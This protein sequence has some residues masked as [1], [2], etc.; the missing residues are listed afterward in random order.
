MYLIT[1]L[2][3]TNNVTNNNSISMPLAWIH[4]HSGLGRHTR[5]TLDSVKLSE[6]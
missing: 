5:V 6:M 3:N 2:A 1:D 4:L